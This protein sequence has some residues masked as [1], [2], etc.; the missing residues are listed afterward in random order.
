[1][2]IFR[3]HQTAGEPTAPHVAERS[4]RA[5]VESGIPTAFRSLISNAMQII[6]NNHRSASLL[7]IG[8]NRA[9]K[10]KKRNADHEIET[11]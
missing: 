3:Y 1:M 9:I 7:N 11:V 8:S 2:M 5:R 4:L 6:E 10:A